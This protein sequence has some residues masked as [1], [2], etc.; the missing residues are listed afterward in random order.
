MASPD[1]GTVTAAAL[2]FSNP[3]ALP[4]NTNLTALV[5]SVGSL[6]EPFSQATTMYGATVPNA[7]SSIQLTSTAADAS[8]L[9]D[10]GLVGSALLPVASGGISPPVTLAEGVNL[11]STQVTAPSGATKTYVVAVTRQASAPRLILPM[12]GSNGSGDGSTL[13]NTALTTQFVYSA[14]MLNYIPPGS[15]ITGMSFRLWNGAT[16]WP[17]TVRNCMSHSFYSGFYL[18]ESSSVSLDER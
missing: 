11:L 14:Q 6:N 17:S 5:P 8:A 7:V 16:T 9:L 13:W 10:V 18:I 2:S 4:S 12:N 1:V 15:A 3:A